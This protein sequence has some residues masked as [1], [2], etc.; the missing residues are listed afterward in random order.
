MAANPSKLGLIAGGGQIPA[1]VRAACADSGRPLFIAA[2]RGFCD[3]ATVAD[4]EHAW[5][6][7]AQ[8]GALL[9]GLRQAGVRDVVL[10]GRVK[11]P[12][13]ASLKPDWVGAKLL[14][15]FA[16]AALKGD[17]AVLRVAVSAFEAEGFSLRGV[18]EIVS[19]LLAPEGH[20][21]G[22]LPSETQQRDIQ[23]ALAAATALGAED[24]GQAAVVARAEIVGLEDQAGT[25]AMLLRLRGNAAARGGVLAKCAKPG[26]ERRVDLPAIGVTTLENAAAAGLS[27]VAVQ[28]GAALVV[29]RPA[30]MAAADRLGLFLVG[31]R[32]NG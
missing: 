32:M 25:D 10:C 13:F 1:L 26:Q 27:G 16:L 22:P 5:F 29:D 4:A 11:R 6:E 28:A 23:A 30:C 7:L 18:D 21:G 3:E 14:P 12:D 20:L 17:D 8:V 24:K 2:L 19:G 15:R 9:N 31:V